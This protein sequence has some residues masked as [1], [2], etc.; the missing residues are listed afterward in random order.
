M[1][2]NLVGF[3]IFSNTGNIH[4][5]IHINTNINTNDSEDNSRILKVVV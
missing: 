2:S 5:N 1:D 4:E 3:P